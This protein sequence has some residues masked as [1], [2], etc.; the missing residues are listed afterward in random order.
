MSL[1]NAPTGALWLIII[2]RIILSFPCFY[3]SLRSIVLS[4]R[5][6]MSNIAISVIRNSVPL[7]GIYTM[8]AELGFYDVIGKLEPTLFELGN[9]P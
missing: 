4:R 2:L 3:V 1:T 5:E 7:D 6:A 9:T 8:G